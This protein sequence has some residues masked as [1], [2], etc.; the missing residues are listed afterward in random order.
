[1]A[2]WINFLLSVQASCDDLVYS[3]EFQDSQNYVERPSLKKINT[4]PQRYLEAESAE[5]TGFVY[6]TEA[7]IFKIKMELGGGPHL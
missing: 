2:F 3:C 6:N 4:K 5:S 1:M 7:K